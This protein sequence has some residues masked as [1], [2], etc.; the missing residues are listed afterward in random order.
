VKNDEIRKEK[1]S[2]SRHYLI[3]SNYKIDHVIANR[4]MLNE[5]NNLSIL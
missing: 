2:S 4:V 3:R 5:Q 1:L